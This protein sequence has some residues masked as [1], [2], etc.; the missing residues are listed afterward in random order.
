MMHDVTPQD[1]LIFLRL[2]SDRKGNLSALLV[3]FADDSTETLLQIAAYPEFH[4]LTG[5]FACLY[6]ADSE[7]NS[8]TPELVSALDNAGCQ[9]ISRHNVF[10]ADYRLEDA[11]PENIG[12]I[13]GNWYMEA[14]AKP[15]NKQAASRAMAT[16]LAQMVAADAETRDLEAVFRRDPTLSYQLLRLVNSLAVGSGRQITS[17]AQAIVIL[18]RQQLRRWLNLMLFAAGDGD[19]RSAML[20]ARVSVRA[21]AMELLARL[22]GL[23]KALQ[24]QAFMIGMFSLLGILFGSPIKEVLKH[25]TISEVMYDAVVN[26]GGELGNLLSLIEFAEQGD[27][28]SLGEGLIQLQV[29]YEDFNLTAIQSFGWMLSVVQDVQGPD[30]A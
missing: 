13:D 7:T 22:S 24:D 10:Q 21:R 8:L 18:G 6:P 1:S 16:Q 4:E 9:P 19:Q 28:A 5:R 23:D 2:L 25:L 11:Y 26:H 29:S 14:P 20:L 17:F 15:N 30:H 27:F 3:D 12:W